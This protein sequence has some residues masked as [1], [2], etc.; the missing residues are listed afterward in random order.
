MSSEQLAVSVQD[1]GKRFILYEKPMH[2][3]CEMLPWCK[4]YGRE[5]VALEN[6]SFQLPRGQVLGLI[7]KMA[8]VNPPCCN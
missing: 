5:F 2:R 6:I 8:Q 3:L 4:R 1:L 7:G